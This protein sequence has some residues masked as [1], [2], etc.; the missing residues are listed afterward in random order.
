MAGQ[1]DVCGWVD[2]E[3]TIRAIGQMDLFDVCV[4]VGF[5]GGTLAKSGKLAASRKVEGTTGLDDP[6]L[7]GTQRDRKRA[8]DALVS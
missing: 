1:E 6:P 3:A 5:G 2:V 7:Q 4:C 8:E